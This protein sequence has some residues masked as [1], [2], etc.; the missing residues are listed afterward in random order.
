[1]Q[2]INTTHPFGRS[3]RSANLNNLFSQLQNFS[4]A[5]SQAKTES[6]RSTP[7]DIL[8]FENAYS[9]E[10]EVPGVSKEAISISV[11]DGVLSVEANSESL[12]EDKTATALRR[13]RYRGNLKRQFSLGEKLDENTIEASL[14]NGVLKIR[15]AKREELKEKVKHIQIN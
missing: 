2:F 8:E 6:S 15:I 1:M 9:L 7:A 4:A 12:T 13:E 11:E 10:I 14:D 5:D 3:Y